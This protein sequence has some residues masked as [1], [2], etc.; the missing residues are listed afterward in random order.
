MDQL[1]KIYQDTGTIPLIGQQMGRPKKP[2]TREESEVINEAYHRFRYGARILEILIR[3][4][5][6][7]TP[8]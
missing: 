1:W 5:Y 7:G 6:N 8:E 4:A 3:G 2:I